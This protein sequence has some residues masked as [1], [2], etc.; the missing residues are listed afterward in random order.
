MLYFSNS[1]QYTQ[2]NYF[3]KM[4]YD[5]SVL[6]CNCNSLFKSTHF[7]E[8]YKVQEE[9]QLSQFLQLSPFCFLDLNYPQL[10]FLYTSDI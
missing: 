10:R 3:V 7:L 1:L 4:F 9:H 6:N 5:K 8:V 2:W